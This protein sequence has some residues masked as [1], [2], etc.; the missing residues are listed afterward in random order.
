M[1]EW[2]R[3]NDVKTFVVGGLALDF[4]VKE[5]ALDLRRAGFKVVL[6]LAATRAISS[7]DA[8]EDTLVQLE[9]AGVI[10]VNNTEDLKSKLDM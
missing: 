2:A 10:F 9:Q 4:C 3:Q 7:G 1:I 5:T 8:L 6:N